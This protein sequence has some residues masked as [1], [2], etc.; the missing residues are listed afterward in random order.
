MS[1]QLYRWICARCSGQSELDCDQRWWLCFVC[2]N[3]LAKKLEEE[4]K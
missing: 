3:D 1:N 4:P 2:A